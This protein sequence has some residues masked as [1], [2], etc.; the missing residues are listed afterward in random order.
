MFQKKVNRDFPELNSNSSKKSVKSTSL[1]ISLSIKYTVF[2]TNLDIIID[3]GSCSITG[4]DF[5]NF[6]SLVQL[7]TPP[8]TFMK[9]ASGNVNIWN[10]RSIDSNNI[11]IWKELYR[12]VDHSFV[13]SIFIIEQI[14]FIIPK[15]FFE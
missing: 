3:Q 8:A 13:S 15:F 14:V 4:N 7:T 6:S 11:A 1:F 9:K 10:S 5:I 12:I 2:S